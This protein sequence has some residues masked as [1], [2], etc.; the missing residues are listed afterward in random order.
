M[1]NFK[2]Y[3]EKFLAIT[4]REQYLITLTGLVVIVLIM[5]NFFIDSNIAEINKHQVVISDASAAIESNTQSIAL[6]EEALVNDPNMQTNKK[7]LALEQNLSA[8]DAELEKLT[9]ELINP[10][11]MRYA[12]LDLLKLE[13]GVSLVSFEV[14]PVESLLSYPA[15]DE[16]AEQEKTNTPIA[17]T[18]Q[19][20]ETDGLY[21]HSI[22]IKLSGRYFQLRDYLQALEGMSWTFFWQTFDYQLKEYPVSELEV[23]LYSLST[24]REFIGV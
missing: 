12:L 9:S 5:F 7:I 2:A 18:N 20:V 4:P 3:S 13:R 21:K 16:N 10:I 22:K 8:V 23:T 19:N 15:P 24:K 6:I 11:E 1:E 14:L 17:S